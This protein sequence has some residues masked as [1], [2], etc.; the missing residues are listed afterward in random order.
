MW[1]EQTRILEI[2]SEAWHESDVKW[3]GL[4]LPWGAKKSCPWAQCDSFVNK[5]VQAFG[6]EKETATHLLKVKLAEI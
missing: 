2:K 1:Q 4:A 3:K 6:M 5:P